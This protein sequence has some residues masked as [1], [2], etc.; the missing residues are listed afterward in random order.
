MSNLKLKSVLYILPFL[1]LTVV[2]CRSAQMITPASVNVTDNKA[3]QM[4]VNWIKDKKTKFDTEMSVNNTSVKP[5]L[6]YLGEM[7][8]A[9]GEVS[10]QLK[11]TFFNTGERTIDFKTGETKIFRMVCVIG[12]ATKGD[13]KIEI[14]KVYANPSSDGKTKGE[15]IGGP[16]T[17]T[18]H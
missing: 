5:I 2:G 1:V 15:A 17:F 14:A 16:I 13:F 3:V 7:S 4:H 11:H 6:F 9:R 12:A 8:C 10:G 18:G